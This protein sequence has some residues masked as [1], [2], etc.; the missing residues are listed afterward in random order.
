MSPL[1]RPRCTDHA[2]PGLLYV[3][4]EGAR[5]WWDLAATHLGDGTAWRELWDLNH[6]RVQADGTVLTSERAVLQPGW[7]VLVP[8]PPRTTDR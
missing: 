7:T 6:G 8:A 1:R 5:T 3:T 4:E 2:D